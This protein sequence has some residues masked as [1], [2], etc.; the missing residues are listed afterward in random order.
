MVQ[1]GGKQASMDGYAPPPSF[2]GIE[3]TGDRICYILDLSDSMLTPL[4]PSELEK[5]PKGPVTGGGAVRLEKESRNKQWKKAF[6]AV[7][8]SKVKH[9]ID[10]ARELLKAS[11]LQLDEEQSFSVLWFGDE[12]GSLGS[13]KGL[14][15]A[16]LANVR[17]VFKEIDA[18]QA[19][20]GAENRPHGTLRGK[21]NLHGALHR[22]FKL[23]GRGSVGAGENVDASTWEEGCDTLF[24]LTDG[25]PTWDDWAAR[26][27]RDP[28]DHAGDPET[29]G[30]LANTP[31]LIFQ[32][33]FMHPGCILDE[34]TRLNL[35][36]K[37]EIHC[38]GMGEA[39]M[40]TF[41]RLA[42][43]GRGEAISLSGG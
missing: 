7:D 13:T 21:T 6:E 19:G 28:E 23:R 24:V 5:F 43:L 2:A 18:I 17:A 27:Q 12:A 3:A 20:P 42:F 31:T 10:A 38:V 39:T 16:S 40:N 30:K 35:F 1:A 29:G 25:A 26:D 15:K 34:A 9:R 11:L 8:W 37:V 36:R 14:V 4:R 33:P 41:E 32:S 22:A